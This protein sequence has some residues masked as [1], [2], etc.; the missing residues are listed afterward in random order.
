MDTEHNICRFF[1]QC[2]GVETR[3]KGLLQV[4]QGYD[5]IYFLLKHGR[6]LYLL[7]RR[8]GYHNSHHLCRW[9]GD[10]GKLSFRY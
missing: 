8:M 2:M 10:Y 3:L 7:K 5:Q 1:E 4:L 6:P 9:Y